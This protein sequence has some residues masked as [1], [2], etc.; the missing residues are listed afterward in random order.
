MRQDRMLRIAYVA[1]QAND[2]NRESTLWNEPARRSSRFAV[3]N[4]SNQPA[5]ARKFMYSEWARGRDML[6]RATSSPL[7]KIW[8]TRLIHHPTGATATT[9]LRRKRARSVTTVSKYFG[10]HSYSWLWPFDPEFCLYFYIRVSRVRSILLCDIVA[11][12]FLLVLLVKE[13]EEENG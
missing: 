4:A 7:L 5:H 1:C 10:S 2:G 3:I 13:G 6:S 8:R 9:E 11:A 12:E